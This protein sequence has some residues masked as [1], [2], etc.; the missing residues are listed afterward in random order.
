MVRDAEEHAAEDR[1]RGELV[2]ARNS[3]NSVIYTTERTLREHADRVPVE[4]RSQAEEQ[5]RTLRSALESDDVTE[6]RNRSAELSV[7]LQNVMQL[8]TDAEA[9]DDGARPRCADG[10]GA[11]RWRPGWRPRRRPGRS[12][13]SEEALTSAIAA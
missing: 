9:P 7:T 4:L 6:I 2:S 11:R 5:I 13:P 10:A 1:K 3:A 8:T 12:Q